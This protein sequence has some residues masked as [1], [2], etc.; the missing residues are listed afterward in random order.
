L[1]AFD[2]EGVGHVSGGAGDGDLYGG[3]AKR[4]RR[5]KPSLPTYLVEGY[6]QY[7]PPSYNKNTGLQIEI[8]GEDN[9]Q[10]EDFNMA[11]EVGGK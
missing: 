10:I 6:P 5:S 9:P 11:S 3:E 2:V 1:R 8:T 4:V 7:L